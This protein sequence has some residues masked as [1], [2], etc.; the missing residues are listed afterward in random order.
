M[1]RSR[2]RAQLALDH[3]LVDLHDDAVELVLDA[4][5]LLAEPR[6]VGLDLL[7][8]VQDLV[9]RGHRQAPLAEEVVRLR[10]PGQLEALAVADPVDQHVQ[11][12]RRG[13]A[14]VLLAQRPGRAVAGVGERGPAG[15]DQ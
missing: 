2:C 8:G 13:D 15:G 3:D 14:G 5:P 9:V 4:V 11:R 7:D 12:S 10:L 1:R 6:D